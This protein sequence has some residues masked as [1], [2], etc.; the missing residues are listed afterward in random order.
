MKNYNAEEIVEGTRLIVTGSLMC[1]LNPW[2]DFGDVLYNIPSDTRL[3][4]LETP[5]HYAGCGRCIKF[6]VDDGDQ[7]FYEFWRTFKSNVEPADRV[8]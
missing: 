3:I 8:S 7:V 5:R 2:L 1:R 6:K 4:A